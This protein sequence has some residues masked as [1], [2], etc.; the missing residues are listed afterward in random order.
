MVLD[1]CRIGAGAADDFGDEAGAEGRHVREDEVPI[2]IGRELSQSGR[3]PEVVHGER[4][5]DGDN[6]VI[7]KRVSISID[8]IGLDTSYLTWEKSA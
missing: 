2:G 7:L 8:S 5:E 3:F 4:S 6:D 1:R